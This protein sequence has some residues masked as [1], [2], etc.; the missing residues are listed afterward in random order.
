M[1]CYSCGY[2]NRADAAYC[3]ECRLALTRPCQSCGEPVPAGASSCSRCGASTASARPH[4]SDPSHLDQKRSFDRPPDSREFRPLLHSQE[5]SS[6]QEQ[7]RLGTE[8]TG[9]VRSL[10]QRQEQQSVGTQQEAWHFRVER[11]DVSGNKLK[12]IPV[13]MRGYT[14]HGSVR[15]GDE[16]HLRG[17]WRHGTLRVEKLMNLTT[18]A[19]VQAKS[20]RALQITI[21]VVFVVIV[22]GFILGMTLSGA[23]EPEGPPS[24]WQEP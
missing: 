22:V 17:R 24:W 12:P 23:M 6:R 5:V 2:E 8:F 3:E 20:Y 1:R 4:H 13:E 10:E 19:Q 18:H 15:D 14:F 9:V 21:V 7:A 11:H 16:V